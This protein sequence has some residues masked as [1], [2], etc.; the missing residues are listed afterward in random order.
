MFSKRSRE[1]EI[2]IDH[3]CSPGLPSVPQGQIFESAVIVCGHCQ[4]AVILMPLRT[5]ERGWC[6]KCDKYLCDDCTE[7]LRVTLE[8]R[9]VERVLDAIQNQ[10][11]HDGT[12][13]V[14]LR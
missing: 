9:D 6:S 11:E 2:L 12:S 8:C 10:A 13:S 14:L 3:R 5:R 4:F 1:G 7:T